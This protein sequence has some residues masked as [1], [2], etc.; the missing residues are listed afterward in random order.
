MS[1][2][3][4]PNRVNFHDPK[5]AK[6]WIERTIA[7][8]PWREEFFSRFAQAV[9]QRFDRPISILELGSGPGLLELLHK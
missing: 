4:V 2:D 1:I 6:E 3:D 5:E 8:R 7:N 9:N